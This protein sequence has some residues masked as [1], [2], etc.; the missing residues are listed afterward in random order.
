MVDAP[1][2]SLV[3]EVKNMFRA[4]LLA[5]D[6]ERG[7]SQD[8]ALVNWLLENEEFLTP[9]SAKDRAKLDALVDEWNAQRGRLERQIPADRKSVV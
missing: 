2:D 1:E 7:T 3:D 6:E 5:V 8:A 4:A 9:V